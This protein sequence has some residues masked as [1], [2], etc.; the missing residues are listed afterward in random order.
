[1]GVSKWVSRLQ[2]LAR[3]PAAEGGGLMLQQPAAM[4]TN[5]LLALEVSEGA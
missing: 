3:L 2:Q 1:M 4:A 5:A